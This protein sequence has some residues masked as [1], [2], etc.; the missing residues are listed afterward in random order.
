MTIDWSA[1]LVLIVSL[2]AV[3]GALASAIYVGRRLRQSQQAFG[4]LSQSE[5]GASMAGSASVSSA[6]VGPRED[7]AITFEADAAIVDAAASQPVT[8][9]DLPPE[10]VRAISEKQAVLVLGSGASA[11]AGLLTGT[12]FLYDLMDRVER[13]LPAGLQEVMNARA[14]KRALADLLVSLGGFSK[15]MD[16]LSAGV[17]RER[18]VTAVRD[19]VATTDGQSSPLHKTLAQLPWRSVINLN[20]DDLAYKTFVEQALEPL[21]SVTARDDSEIPSQSR[22]GTRLLFE[23]F[24]DFGRLSS[25]ALTIDEMRRQMRRSPEFSRLLAAMSQTN[26]FFFIGVG[27]DTIEQFLQAIAPDFDAVGL[28]HFALVPEDPTNAVRQSTLGRFGVTMLSYGADAK[29]SAVPSFCKRLRS[30][31][32]V[33]MSN[34]SHAKPP[35]VLSPDRITHVRLVNVGPFEE[36]DLPIGMQGSDGPPGWS[37]IFGS[38]GVGKSTILRAIALAMAGSNPAAIKAGARLLREGADEGLVEVHI[39]SQQLRTTL[40]RDRS[41][42]LVSSLQET[43]LGLGTALVLGFPAMRGARAASPSGPSRRAEPSDPDPADLIALLSGDVDGRLADFK[44][45]LVNTLVDVEGNDRQTARKRKLLD[46]LITELVPGQITALAPL[47]QTFTI[48]VT[49]PEGPVPF[50]ELSQGMASVFNWVG[51]LV[52]RLFSVCSLSENPAEE[53]AI[54]LIDEIDAH[55]H[56]DWQRRLVELTKRHFPN[57]QL[58]VTSHSALLA[59]ALHADEIRVLE[60]RPDRKGVYLFPHPIDLYGRRAQDILTSPVFGLESD[61]NPELERKV[62]DYFAIFEDPGRRRERRDELIAMAAELRTYGY[63]LD[64]TA[65][66]VENKQ[67]PTVADAAAANRIAEHM[68]KMA[69][70]AEP[71]PPQARNETS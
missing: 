69:D 26:T 30:A 15:L 16:A 28:R 52:Q 53:P 9:P 8:V 36:L 60:R 13:H 22:A 62:R 42:V 49:T 20:W 70:I 51:L 68:A 11:Q 12:D 3:L 65:G 19:A 66:D 4:I 38:N 50:D 58:I 41:S 32:R 40:V 34:G 57:L 7:F 25:I 55:L 37:V 6:E 5:L 63:M 21:H 1:G 54:V 67:I 64:P 46:S 43:P 61:R 39:G 2:L 27:L 18:L 71:S 24:G 45:W 29:H 47:D 10:L 17:S 44:Q 59:G 48:R 23:P 33:G 31:A 35:F 14:P 56:P